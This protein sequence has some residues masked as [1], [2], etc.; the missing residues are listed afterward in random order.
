MKVDGLQVD[1]LGILERLWM[2]SMSI[3]V[4]A[5]HDLNAG[6]DTGQCASTRLSSGVRAILMP[7][8]GCH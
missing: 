5:L 7:D 1:I 3:F 8:C 4:D 6:F 2:V